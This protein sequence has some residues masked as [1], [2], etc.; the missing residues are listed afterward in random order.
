[1]DDIEELVRSL[2]ERFP[3]VPHTGAGRLFSTV[4]RMKA[5]KE[6][7][8]P[9]SRRTGFVI[10][11][12]RGKPANELDESQWDEFFSELCGQLKRDYPELYQ[13]V[14]PD[15]RHSEEKRGTSM[16]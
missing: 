10:S 3:L 7:G 2:E 5:E 6:M 4:R 11:V 1:M 15:D 12:N 9:V 14:F 16:E 13:Q 8:I